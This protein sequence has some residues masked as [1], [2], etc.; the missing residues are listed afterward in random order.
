ICKEMAEHSKVVLSGDGGDEMFAGYDRYLT[1]RQVASLGRIQLLPPIIGTVGRLLSSK[2]PDAGRRMQ[3]AATFAR[4]PRVQ[5]LCALHT[6]FSIEES[7]AM[8]RPDFFRQA[9]AEGPTY[10]R[11]GSYVPG[12]MSDA[13]EQLNAA[14]ISSL[15]H[16]DF[17]R[18]VD[19][20]SS[21]HSLEVRTRFLD[22]EVFDLAMKLPMSL[23]IKNKS[24]KYIPRLLARKLL[25]QSVVDRPKQGFAIPFDRWASAELRGFLADLLLTPS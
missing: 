5:M 2:Y 9:L 20:G 11:F 3:K 6:H 25:P 1:A 24:L 13:C 4:L 10:E 22:R 15:L 16:Y 12:A 8:F 7:S 23:R 18:K 19:V 14:E 21:A 17:L